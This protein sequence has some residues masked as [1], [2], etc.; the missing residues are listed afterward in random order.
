[1]GV[2]REDNPVDLSHA[3]HESKTNPKA[4]IHEK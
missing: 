3:P 2:S 1:M 4:S